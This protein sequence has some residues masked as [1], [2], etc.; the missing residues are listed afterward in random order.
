MLMFLIAGFIGG[1]IRGVLGILKYIYSYKNVPMK[2]NYFTG[3]AFVS[4]LIGLVFV[5]MVEELEVV[6]SE[7]KKYLRQLL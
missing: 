2:W 5:L 4:G 7:W 3:T 6:F 1:T